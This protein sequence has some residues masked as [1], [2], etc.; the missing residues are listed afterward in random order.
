V[1]FDSRKFSQKE[2]RQ[3]RHDGSYL[4]HGTIDAELRRRARGSILEWNERMM[5]EEKPPVINYDNDEENGRNTWQSRRQQTEELFTGR[6]AETPGSADITA[7]KTLAKF[8]ETA[9]AAAIGTR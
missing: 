1:N 7:A 9:R 8:D 5:T 2:L 4:N 6:K 3:L